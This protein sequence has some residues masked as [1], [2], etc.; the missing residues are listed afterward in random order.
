ME[1]KLLLP[2]LHELQQAWILLL[3][4][5]IE[6]S[7]V[8]VHL[9][10]TESFLGQSH[11]P[12]CKEKQEKWWGN[13]DGGSR[14]EQA[15]VL[16]F[17]G[18]MTA[19]SGTGAV[20]PGIANNPILLLPEVSLALAQTHPLLSPLLVHVPS[21]KPTPR[22]RLGAQREWGLLVFCC[23]CFLFLFLFWCCCSVFLLFFFLVG[24]KNWFPCRRRRGKR[25]S[26]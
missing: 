2:N 3:I 21:Y 9:F 17:I 8:K 1:T 14:L 23:C 15:T 5:A 19:F 18:H 7:L 20:M 11:F 24:L 6:P 13:E 22:N 10:P 16:I 25:M 12:S 26:C 4:S